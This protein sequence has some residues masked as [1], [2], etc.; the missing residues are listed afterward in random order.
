MCFSFSLL[1]NLHQ[2][3]AGENLLASFLPARSLGG[4]GRGARSSQKGEEEISK[5]R[6][7]LTLLAGLTAA[8]RGAGL[9]PRWQLTWVP[10]VADGMGREADHRNT[11]D[12]LLCSPSGCHRLGYPSL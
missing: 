12:P 4:E 5:I 7:S 2:Q 8:G 9:S 10:R 3:P 6:D 11:T 1:E